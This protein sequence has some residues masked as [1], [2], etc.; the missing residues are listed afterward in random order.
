LTV[1]FGV[2]ACSGSNNLNDLFGA[3]A[4]GTSGGAGAAA[5]AM[6]PCHLDAGQ[7]NDQGTG[8]TNST[9]AGSGG[10]GGSSSGTAGSA[11][12]GTAS[13]DGGSVDMTNRDAGYVVEAGLPPDVVPARDAGSDDVALRDA[14]ISTGL[15]V[16]DGIDNDCD[17]RTDERGCPDGCIG[18]TRDGKGYLFCYGFNRRVGWFGSESECTQ[19]GMH[20]VRI[21]DAAE[22]QWIREMATAAGYNGAIWIGASDRRVEGSWEWTDGTEFWRGRVGGMSVGGLYSN[23]AT[24]QPNNA[25][26]NE[27]C[28]SMYQNTASWYDETCSTD[29]AYLCER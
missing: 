25:S 8:G 29:H 20:L 15:E 18:T 5:C 11:G 28:V 12:S 21:D 19:R 9:P 10:T 1:A 24:N 4:G 23:W 26:G 22:N 14:C 3:G 2:G 7:P 16:C 27:D 13:H 17:G 6:M